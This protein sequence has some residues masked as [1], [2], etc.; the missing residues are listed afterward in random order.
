MR[1]PSR[2]SISP[3]CA[4]SGGWEPETRAGGSIARVLVEEN[5]WRAQRWGVEAELADYA[6][7]CLKPMS[8]LVEELIE[9][10]RDDA[11]ELG[12]LPELER[13]REIVANGTSADHQLAVYNKPSEA[14][15]STSEAQRAVVEWLVQ[16]T[17]PAR[18]S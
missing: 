10:L 11:A 18:P 7:G 2:R 9:L 6:A 8:A 16:A 13:A 12:C 1:S 4:T 5:K 3:C 15:A 14:G 17:V